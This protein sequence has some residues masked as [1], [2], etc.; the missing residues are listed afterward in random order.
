MSLP[1]TAHHYRKD[2]DGLRAIAVLLVVIFHAFP[3]AMPGGFIGVDIFFV[4]SGYLISTIILTDLGLGS[5]SFKHF[6]IRRIKRILPALLTVLSACLIFGWFALLSD[7]YQSLG[8]HTLAGALFISNILLWSES[9]YFDTLAELKPLL[10]LWSL[11]IEEQFYLFSPLILWLASKFK[12]HLLIAIIALALYS[13][14]LNLYE[15]N[16][17]PVAVFY[18]PLTRF[19]ELL[20]G[21]ML[22]WCKLYCKGDYFKRKVAV[23]QCISLLGLLFIA[24]SSKFID[25]YSHFPGW[26][27]LLPVLGT[28]CLIGAGEKAW[29]NR[30]LLSNRVMVWIGLISFPLYLW[31][32]PILTFANLI[33]GGEVRSHVRFWLM[34]LAIAFS[35]LTYIL[36]EKPIRFGGH[37]TRKVYAL[38]SWLAL[39]GALGTHIVISKGYPFR[40][41]LNHITFTEAV[42]DQLVGAEWKYKQNQSCLNQHPFAEAREYGWWFCIQNKENP[43]SIIIL[44][45]SFANH[46]YPGFVNNANFREKS[47]LS[48]GSCAVGLADDDP[49]TVGKHPCA[50]KRPSSER[51]FIY[52]LIAKHQSIQ[53]VIL[54]GFADQINPPY[55]EGVRDE[56][57]ALKRYPVQLIVFTPHIQPNFDPKLCY[58]T[59]FRKQVKDCSFSHKKLEELQ[60]QFEPIKNVIL[61][62]DP[63]ALF[64]DPNAMYCNDTN[65]SYVTKGLP[66]NRDQGHISEYGSIELQKYFTLWAAKNVPAILI[67]E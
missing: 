1:I 67:A 36:V 40:A 17:D 26:W 28:A 4:I 62:A 6:Y 60:R 46:L 9:G 53:Y 16:A 64:F 7:E 54:S 35:W 13:F 45:S 52:Q 18:S 22:A 41:Q 58:S 61:S 31:H 55:L 23:S 30:Y 14:I 12:V 3:K 33:E 11:G 59:P 57:L 63:S 42:R 15:L 48:I 39:L 49:D 20:V 43:P 34:L 21:A 8:K 47:I 10:H 37:S 66:L 29:I 56:V 25:K 38:I 50:Y 24:L 32:W 44:G 19:W 65:C 2:I 51:A 5:F 27:A